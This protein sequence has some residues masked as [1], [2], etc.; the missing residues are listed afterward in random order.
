MLRYS[1]CLAMHKI[2]GPQ[3][4]GEPELPPKRKEL[5][6]LL[7]TALNYIEKNNN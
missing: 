4:Y 5:K 3:Y 1:T 6:K 2:A 7:K